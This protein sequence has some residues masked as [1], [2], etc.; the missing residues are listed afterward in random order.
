MFNQSSLIC[1]LRFL[2]SIMV[3][4]EIK[5]EAK[6]ANEKS[7]KRKNLILYTALLSLEFA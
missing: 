4:N 2:K 3:K 6:K 1:K 7:V 5:A